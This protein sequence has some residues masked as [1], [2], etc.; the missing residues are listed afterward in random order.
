MSMFLVYLNLPLT[1]FMYNQFY[2]HITN[3]N[4]S[5]WPGG[6]RA[7]S[8]LPRRWWM[9]NLIKTMPTS[10]YRMNMKKPWVKMVMNLIQR[11]KLTFIFVSTHNFWLRS[12]CLQKTYLTT[13]PHF[14][15]SE[16]CV[17]QWNSALL[18][19]WVWKCEESN[20]VVVWKAEDLP[21]PVSYGVGL[22]EHSW[23]VISPL[24]PSHCTNLVC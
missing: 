12:Q 6:N 18:D 10:R 14:L 5:R 15:C 19:N 8:T 7:G 24:L 13:P 21:S 11:I 2:T 9:T 23:F 1:N 16:N 3:S 4:I 20:S 22:L 17:G